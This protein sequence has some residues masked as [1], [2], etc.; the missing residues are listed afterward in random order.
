[1]ADVLYPNMASYLYIY[2]NPR[3]KLVKILRP[4]LEKRREKAT[5]KAPTIVLKG[6]QNVPQIDQNRVPEPPGGPKRPKV[7]RLSIL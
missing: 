1:M 4:V 7:T 5:P 6:N 3:R 2:L